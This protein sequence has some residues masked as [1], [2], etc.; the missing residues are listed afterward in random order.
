M[1]AQ[2]PP[3]VPAAVAAVV[4]TQALTRLG[5]RITTEEASI[6]GR[7]TV[8]ALAADG[9][10]IA[11]TP[12]GVRRL[13][14][15]SP[16]LWEH[17]LPVLAGLARGRTAR[18]IATEMDTPE[19]T[20]RQRIARLLGRTGA[21]NSAELLAIAYQSGW[22]AALAP[23]PRGPI[24]LTQQQLQILALIADGLD[25][26]AIAD[27]LGMPLNTAI[28]HMR[29]VYAALDATRPGQRNHSSRCLAVAL[30]YQHG[31]LPFPARP[32]TPAA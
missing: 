22:M 29:R 17:D 23:E 6:L 26:T 16:A 12:A 13:S 28:G 18:E 14:Q 31:L 4:A 21:A 3:R 15:V 32:A 11:P 7:A 27:V 9:W 24:T 30:A 19:P 10:T 25:N 5:H 20:V 8:E 1:T 2:Q